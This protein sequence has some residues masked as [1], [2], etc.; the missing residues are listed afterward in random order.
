MISQFLAIQIPAPALLSVT[1]L[2]FGLSLI[3]QDV[4]ID[5]IE[6]KALLNVMIE[7]TTSELAR[8][9]ASLAEV[10]SVLN[11]LGT[12][13]TRDEELRLA[14]SEHV[15]YY[16][17]VITSQKEYLGQLY[18]QLGELEKRERDT[19]RN[20]K[21]FG[22]PYQSERRTAFLDLI[23]KPRTST[24]RFGDTGKTQMEDLDAELFAAIGGLQNRLNQETQNRQEANYI[25]LDREGTV[26][27]IVEMQKV[28]QGYFDERF[29]LYDKMNQT[30]EQILRW[31]P[32]LAI[33]FRPPPQP[34]P[35]EVY[36]RALERM[37]K[38]E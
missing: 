19:L 29:V 25:L 36:K 9:E 27:T 7:D 22:S 23:L 31:R 8:N 10:R 21:N 1:L 28:S 24:A 11:G 32:D 26:N 20:L 5:S 33:F 30:Y 12:G 38:E 14:I 15:E 3:A 17:E 4:A 6:D 18:D 35:P 13:S 2:A 37:Q 16:D 34:K